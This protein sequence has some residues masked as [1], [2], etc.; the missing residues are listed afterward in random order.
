MFRQSPLCCSLCCVWGEQRQELSLLLWEQNSELM[1]LQEDPPGWLLSGNQCYR[2]SFL[3]LPDMNGIDK[4]QDSK[5]DFLWLK[6][7]NLQESKERRDSP[8]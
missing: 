5:W 2:D 7:L 6:T 8:L 1:A 3:E 4:L